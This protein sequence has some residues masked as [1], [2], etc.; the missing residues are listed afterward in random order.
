MNVDFIKVDVE[1]G[2]LFTFLGGTKTIDLNKPIVF[3]EILRKYCLKYYYDHN[4]IFQWFYKSG[5]RA[6]TVQGQK[7]LS[8]NLMDE[9]TI[10]TNFFFL[11]SEKH[12]LII[13]EL[14]LV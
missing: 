4:E 11:H 5:Y 10:E 13:S 2:E 7:L 8:F 9:N 12:A 3:T 14:E 1:G 6:F